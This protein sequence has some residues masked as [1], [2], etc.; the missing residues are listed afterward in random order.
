MGI[1]NFVS[2]CNILLFLYNY[3]LLYIYRRVFIASIMF[4]ILIERS[5]EILIRWTKYEGLQ[6]KRIFTNNYFIIGIN[7]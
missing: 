2:Y 6:V 4:N 1:C 5:K 3:Y 7:Y